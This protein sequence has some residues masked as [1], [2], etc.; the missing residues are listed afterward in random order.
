MINAIE[1]AEFCKECP[2]NLPNYEINYIT[3]KMPIKNV[4]KEY[5][6][7]IKKKMLVIIK[8]IFVIMIP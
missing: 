2:F 8:N 4:M 1:S 3:K 5:A 7:K 6:L